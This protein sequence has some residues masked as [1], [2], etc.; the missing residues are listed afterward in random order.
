MKKS[1]FL[2]LTFFLFSCSGYR[3]SAYYIDK[4]VGKNIYATVE[5]IAEEPQN[6]FLIED[7]LKEALKTRLNVN[8]SNRQNSDSEIRL[9]L[10][11]LEF[12]PLQYNENGYVIL[13]RTEIELQA[14]HTYKREE[15][16]LSHIYTL[17]GFYEFPVRPNVSISMAIRFDAIKFSALKAIDMLVPK[18][19]QRG[20]TL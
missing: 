4:V 5:T 3:P 12:K 6:S 15:E 14:K 13:Y 1:I 16:T 8:F 20:S 19:A 7:A 2:L 17:R 11:N 18:L 10:K 9:S